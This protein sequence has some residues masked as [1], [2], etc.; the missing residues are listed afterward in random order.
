MIL[1]VHIKICPITFYAVSDSWHVFIKNLYLFDFHIGRR[2]V[3][4]EPCKQIVELRNHLIYI[5]MLDM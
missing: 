3:E 4:T 2:K 1:L 5:L